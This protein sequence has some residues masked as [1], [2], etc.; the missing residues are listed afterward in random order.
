MLTVLPRAAA[1]FKG[2]T[3]KGRKRE[4]REGNGKG[5]KGRERG[6]DALVLNWE[7][8]KVATLADDN[9]LFVPRTQTVTFGPLAAFSISGP[10][11]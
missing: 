4:G 1:G 9:K 10:D 6:R 8:E 11:A 2:P 3:S 5:G 7:N